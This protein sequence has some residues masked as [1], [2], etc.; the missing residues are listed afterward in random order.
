MIE[1]VF[2]SHSFLPPFFLPLTFLSTY[3]AAI[4]QRQ[5]E[6]PYIVC[7]YSFGGMLAF[8]I[9]KKLEAMNLEVDF[10]AVLDTCPYIKH[11]IQLQLD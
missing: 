7:G 4:R 5:P 8:E 3:P 11:C 9:T 1:F 6:G 10:C 2:P